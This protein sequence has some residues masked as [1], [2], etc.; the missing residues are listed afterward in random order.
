MVN[1]AIQITRTSNGYI[2]EWNEE[3]G[4]DFVRILYVI[5]EPEDENYEQKAMEKLL[6]FIM[7]YFGI[8]SPKLT[9]MQKL[10][11]AIKEYFGVYSSKHNKE[12]LVI[13]IRKTDE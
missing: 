11:Y 6:R 1:Y 8:H 7:K 5:E 9:A 10:L 13:E 3:Q 12:N 2:L 4:D